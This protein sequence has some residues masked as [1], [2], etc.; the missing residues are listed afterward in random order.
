MLGF[1]P[2]L[3][4][5]AISAVPKSYAKLT[6]PRRIINLSAQLWDYSSCLLHLSDNIWQGI[7]ILN[8][9][10]GCA[11]PVPHIR[12]DGGDC[13]KAIVSGYP[14]GEFHQPHPA[15]QMI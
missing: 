9:F 1:Y 2:Y 10:L 6:Y 5:S 4:V 3:L 8:N 7:A 12:A 14:Q 15:D 13:R 11:G